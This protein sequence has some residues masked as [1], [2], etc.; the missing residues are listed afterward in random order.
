MLHGIFGSRR[1]WQSVSK[2]LSNEIPGKIVYPLDLRNHG[3]FNNT[4]AVV[5]PIESW[6]TLINDLE[7]FW[8]GNLGGNDFDLLGHSF[9]AKHKDCVVHL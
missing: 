6:K 7:R 1:N 3:C 2:Q 4:Q 8:K 5:G 9:V